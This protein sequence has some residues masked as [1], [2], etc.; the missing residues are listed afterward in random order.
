[1]GAVVI[2]ALLFGLGH[3]G[4]AALASP[5]T[6]AVVARTVLLNALVGTAFGWLYWRPNLE[7]GMLAHASRH[8][9]VTFVSWLV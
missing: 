6:P 9:T 1:M 7:T 5:L 8:V 3:L 2:S 4:A